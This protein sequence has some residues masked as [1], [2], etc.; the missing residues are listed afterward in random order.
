MHRT[1]QSPRSSSFIVRPLDGTSSVHPRRMPAALLDAAHHVISV[2][3]RLRWAL[4]LVPGPVAMSA[5]CHDISRSVSASLTSRHQVL[6]GTAQS[7]W[8][9]GTA[10]PHRKAA[11]EAVAALAVESELT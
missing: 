1:L 4:A 3:G 5:G 10:E 11:V 9:A 2:L 8:M 6:S 7:W